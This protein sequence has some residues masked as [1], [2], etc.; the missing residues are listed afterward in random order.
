MSDPAKT[1]GELEAELTNAHAYIG[2]LWLAVMRQGQDIV[3]AVQADMLSMKAKKAAAR[4]RSG[5]SP[6][7]DTGQDEK[8]KA[9][10]DDA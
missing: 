8:Q 9:A 2:Q 5:I 4:A 1:Y 3:D 10:K 6:S 7:S